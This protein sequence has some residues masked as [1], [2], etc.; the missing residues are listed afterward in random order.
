MSACSAEY[1]G[2]PH[3]FADLGFAVNK[4]MPI[5]SSTTACSAR[6]LNTR[7]FRVILPHVRAHKD[8]GT[9][10]NG[11]SRISFVLMNTSFSSMYALTMG[12]ERMLSCSKGTTSSPSST[13]GDLA[14]SEAV[15]AL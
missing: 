6:M 13:S 12:A 9:L 8:V 2:T 10:G 7:Y 5:V 3:S 11:F 4:A 15:D 1:E 14:D